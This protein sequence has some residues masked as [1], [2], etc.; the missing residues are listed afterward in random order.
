MGKPIATR[1]GDVLILLTEKSF[2]VYAV[3]QVSKDG[4]QDFHEGSV[5]HETDRAAA[6][7]AAKALLAPGR[8]ILLRNLDA[9]DW[10]E[11]T[12]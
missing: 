9:D 10:S 7:A 6:V 1:V 5:K 8:R 2:T 12:N 3:G 4:Q 11:I